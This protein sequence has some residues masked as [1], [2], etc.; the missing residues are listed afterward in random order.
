MKVNELIAKLQRC[1]DDAEVY[2]E[3]DGLNI[4]HDV[5]ETW[6]D[7]EGYVARAARNEVEWVVYIVPED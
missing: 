1:H 5:L 4:A 7:S 3:S 6:D 2:I